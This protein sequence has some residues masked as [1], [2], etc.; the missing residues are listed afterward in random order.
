MAYRMLLGKDGVT[1]KA[2]KITSTLKLAN[3]PK[4]V[5]DRARTLRDIKKN[6][7]GG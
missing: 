6:L 5:V 4:E 7:I 1:D 3:P 2:W